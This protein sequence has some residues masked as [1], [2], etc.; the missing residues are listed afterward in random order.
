ML[1]V[2]SRVTDLPRADYARQTVQK[3]RTDSIYAARS[4]GVMEFRKVTYA[5]RVDGLTVPAYLFAPIGK[6]RVCSRTPRVS[7][8]HGPRKPKR[9]SSI[10]ALD[11]AHRCAAH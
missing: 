7:I 4:A 2:S 9:S 11:P 1:Y 3:Q 10:S 5:S 6:R 8:P